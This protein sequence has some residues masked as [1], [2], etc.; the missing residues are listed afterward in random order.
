MKVSDRRVAWEAYNVRPLLKGFAVVYMQE[1]LLR[2]R[3]NLP[4]NV[5]VKMT[6]RRIT[7]WYDYFN[8]NVYLS[9]SGG[10]DS[11]VLLHI[12]RRIGLDIPVVF[13]DTWMEFPQVRQFV[14][15][16]ENIIT[17]KPDKS[18][19]QII[20]DDGWCFPSKD[21]AEMI[22][23]VRRDKKW[24]IKKI[25]GLDKNGNKSEFRQQY[26]KRRIIVD[27][28]IKISH[29]CCLDMKEI[30]VAKY[31]KETGNK[32]IL[33][34]MAEE[35]QRRKEA[36]LRT[37]CNGF[38]SQRPVSKSMGFWTGQDVLNYIKM[39]NIKIAELYGKIIP[40]DGHKKLLKTNCKLCCSGMSRTG[41]MFCPVG[42]HLNKDR[43][44]L[45]KH[46]NSKLYDYIMEELNMKQLVDF[47]NNNF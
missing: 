33:A 1:S 2:Y 21:V 16:H 36:Y 4:L 23:G 14:K 18:L 42:L 11:T 10:K 27:A 5:K 3:Q 34:L 37:V 8:G 46:F 28:P 17:I 7:D 25:N 32:P 30:P 44:K 35:S 40:C 15:E 47:I 31:E 26:K 39:N 19:K 13:L 9:F 29:R 45:V 12:A 24:A 20:D 41:C 43:L 22:D 38:N 6:E